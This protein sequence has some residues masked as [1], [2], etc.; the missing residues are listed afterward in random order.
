[1]ARRTVAACK[2]ELDEASIEDLERIIR[3]HTRDE[4]EGVRHAVAQ[5]RRRLKSLRAEAT[6]LAHL[7]ELEA[8][9]R[10]QGYG[11]VAGLDEVG[12]GALAGP[13]TAAAVILPPDAAIAGLDDSKRLTPEK[14]KYLSVVIKE[15]AVAWRIAHVSSEEID[16]L[17]IAGATR[18]AMLL[19]F[20]SLDPRPDHVVVDGRGVGIGV[21]ET[22]VVGGDGKVAAVA[23]AS[24]IAKVARD[25]L[26]CMVAA[27]HPA[28]GFEVNKGYGTSEH[29]RALNDHGLCSLHRRSFA[30]CGGTLP[31][32]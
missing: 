10:A 14:R 4:R 8:S 5:A 3:R 7:A 1:V 31:L 22:A 30:P 16:A 2:A 9:L 20:E 24:V 27:D 12:R 32:F 15:T 13:V 23:A 11:L 18:R 19:A 26:M 17:G 6:R 25:A 29:L 21:P 28:Y